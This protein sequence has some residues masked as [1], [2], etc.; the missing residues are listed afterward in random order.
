MLFAALGYAIY[1]LIISKLGKETALNI[2]FYT[3]LFC[4][5]FALI[6]MLLESGNKFPTTILNGRIYSC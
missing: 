3:T 6:P 1:L 4:S 5:I 2:I